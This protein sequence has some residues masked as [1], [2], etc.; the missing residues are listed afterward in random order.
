MHKL[1]DVCDRG[2]RANPKGSLVH[3][4]FDF[5]DGTPLIERGWLAQPAQFNIGH[6]L[7]LVSPDTDKGREL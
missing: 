7:N 3:Y 2:I 4:V 1:G 6:H 5:H